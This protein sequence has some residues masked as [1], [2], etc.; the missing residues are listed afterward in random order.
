MSATVIC[1]IGFNILARAV[2]SR[3]LDL[4][5]PSQSTIACVVL[6][7]GLT[8]LANWTHTSRFIGILEPAG[9]TPWTNNATP[10]PGRVAYAWTLSSSLLSRTAV[11]APSRAISYYGAHN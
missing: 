1:R 5:A 8:H 10:S 6:S 2:N 11:Y 7:V 9:P 3:V 4:S